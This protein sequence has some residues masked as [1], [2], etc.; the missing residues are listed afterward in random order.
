MGTRFPPPTPS[1]DWGLWL[2][3]KTIDIDEPPL[4]RT[5][6]VM[7][8]RDPE[9]MKQYKCEWYVKN[10]EA[11]LKRKQ[12]HRAAKKKQQHP[13]PKLPPSP[14]QTVRRKE[15]NRQACNR[16]RDSHREKVRAINRTYYHSIR[17]R[18]VRQQCERRANT[19]NPFRKLGALAQVCAKRLR[20]LYHE[21]MSLK[22]GTTRTIQG[23][24]K[25][26]A[27]DGM[28]NMKAINLQ[29][30]WEKIAWLKAEGEY[31]MFKK[32]KATLGKRSYQC[33]T[34]NG[35]KC[36]GKILCQ[37]AWI[38]K[39][40][41]E[42]TFED[43]RRW[44]NA[45][46]REKTTKKKRAMGADGCK[47]SAGM[48]CRSCEGGQT[49]PLELVRR[50]SGTS[51]SLTMA[52]SRVNGIREWGGGGHCAGNLHELFRSDGP[53]LVTKPNKMNCVYIITSL[54]LLV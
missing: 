41:R 46:H 43:Y 19:K 53:L 15:L 30:Y 18:I 47:D 29:R 1:L 16:C 40:V 9:N 31:E 21:S 25:K 37:K 26:T 52:T 45:R 7:P 11:I 14:E 54:L 10:R 22:I 48:L 27:V 2:S 42:G 20:S 24:E 33:Q 44:L 35:P 38:E 51:L 3:H 5:S 32:H 23:E 12:Q 17:E 6:F 13:Q 50:P 49:E 34:T 4:T 39:M 8:N 28:V 36:A